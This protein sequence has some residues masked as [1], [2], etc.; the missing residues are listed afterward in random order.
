MNYLV[1]WTRVLCDVLIKLTEGPQ[2]G[3]EVCDSHK[4][5]KFKCIPL[6]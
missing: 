1:T 4:L 5:G 2:L 6:G 3:N